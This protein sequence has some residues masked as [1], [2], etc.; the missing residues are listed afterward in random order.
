MVSA[1]LTGAVVGDGVVAKQA[2]R[3]HWRAGVR[4]AAI[5]GAALVVPQETS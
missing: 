4:R 5:G 3:G 2:Q 1:A